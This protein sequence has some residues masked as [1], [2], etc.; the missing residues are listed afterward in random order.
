MEIAT[1]ACASCQPYLK[2]ISHQHKVRKVKYLMGIGQKWDCISVQYS[3]K[4][5]PLIF[6]TL[7]AA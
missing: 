6:F 7:S 2:D 1:M 3:L 5:K 4:V